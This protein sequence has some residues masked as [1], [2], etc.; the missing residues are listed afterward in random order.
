MTNARP[1]GYVPALLKIIEQAKRAIETAPSVAPIFMLDEEGGCDLYETG[2]DIDVADVLTVCPTCVRL[3]SVVELAHGLEALNECEVELDDRGMALYPA[4][5]DRDR[6]TLA[7]V[8]GWADCHQPFNL[9]TDWIE[10]VW[11]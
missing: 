10:V 7:F 8:C 2:A 3:S 11:G 4:K 5:D 9:P 1:K 6:H